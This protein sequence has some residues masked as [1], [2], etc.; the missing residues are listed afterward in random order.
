MRV[1]RRAVEGF[2]GRAVA[3]LTRSDFVKRLDTDPADAGYVSR[4]R[5]QTD[6]RHFLG[7]RRDREV[8]QSDRAR[9]RAPG[10][11]RDPPRPGAH[12]RGAE[13]AFGRI[14]DG[15]A[16]SDPMRVLLHP[17]REG[18]R[19]R[20][21]RRETWTSM[22]GRSLLGPRSALASDAR[23]RWT[24][25]WSTCCGSALRGRERDGFAF[26]E[27]SGFQ[28]PFSGFSKASRDYGLQ[29]R[30]IRSGRPCTT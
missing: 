28:R 5:A 7:C 15:S 26:G 21:C 19:P 13:G 24:M 17:R 29:C 14:G 6:F 9:S 20:R 4:N 30:R 10:R 23:S 2:N 16:Y 18:T 8:G 25:R 11:A 27:G 1:P 12:R 22:R 3:L